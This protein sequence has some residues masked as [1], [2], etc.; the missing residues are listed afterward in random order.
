MKEKLRQDFFRMLATQENREADNILEQK[1]RQ[2]KN[3]LS[4]ENLFSALEN[5]LRKGN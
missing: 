5:Y 1:L 3:E 4:K 2:I